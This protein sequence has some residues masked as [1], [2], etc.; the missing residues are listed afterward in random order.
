MNKK[1]LGRIAAA[2]MAAMTAVSAMSVTA[3]AMVGNNGVAS[4]SVYAVVITTPGTTQP[5]GVTTPATSQTV[6]Y[7][8]SETANAAISAIAPTQTATK[9]ETTVNAAFGNG[10]TIYVGSDGKITRE[11][12]GGTKYTTTGTTTTTPGT[13]TPSY[14]S[15]YASSTNNVYLGTN[16]K[17][18][19]NLSSLY[20]AGTSLSNTIPKPEQLTYQAALNAS[21]T[22]V[23]YFNKDTGE[24]SADVPS[25]TDWVQIL[26]YSSNYD[27]YY[28]TKPA[29]FDTYDVYQVGG[30]YYPTLSS[31]LSAAGNNYN[32]ITK[33]YDY[34]RP[35]T[36]YF[37]KVTG[38]YY[39]TY[40]DALAASRNS[41][42][43]VYTFSYYSSDYYYDD[44]YG[45]GYGDP[46]Y[47]Y[48]LRKQNGTDDTSSKNDTT[49]ATVGNRK[50]WTA[51]SKYL[52]SLKTGSSVTVSMNN[53][54]TVPASAMSAI[55]GKNVTVKFVLKNGVVFTINGRDVSSASDIDIDTSYNTSRVP[56]KL[57][58]AAY[59]KNKAVS[60]AQISISGGSFGAEADVTVKFATKR[61]GCTAKL[62]RYN[63][64]KETLSLVDTAKVQSNGKCTFGDVDKGGN[65]VII[66]S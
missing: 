2:S 65:F 33:I 5:N 21:A 35:Q 47:Y 8:S 20:A 50:G 40:A 19:P 41:A 42:S 14:S 15:Q 64:G 17:Y 60:S 23:V 12:Y 38:K 11:N 22:K 61:A 66:L 57:V 59:K 29:N 48:W 25:G 1:T 52:S 39:S 49:T 27:Y 43:N 55:K 13:T 4:G 3:S 58:K 56:S 9:T 44:L 10:T 34:S 28:N 18:Y 26:G 54:T 6:Y 7:T 63:S 53:E 45:Y 51:V 36:N 62:Y 30:V 16:G 46:Y 31:A 37:S 24:F 32:L